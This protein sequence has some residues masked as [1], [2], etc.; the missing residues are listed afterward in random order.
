MTIFNSHP[1]IDGKVNRDQFDENL[2][3]YLFGGMLYV[4]LPVSPTA[5]S[6]FSPE[7]LGDA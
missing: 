2:L 5:L 1:Q 7:A 6:M 4:S 3:F